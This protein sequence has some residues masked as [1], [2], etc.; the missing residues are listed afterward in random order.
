MA[1]IVTRVTGTTAVNRPLTN[2]EIDANFINL[3]AAIV[4]G[5]GG[6]LNLDGGIPSSN[7]GGIT[8]IN[9]GTP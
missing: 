5:G 9:G 8:A 1:T 7:Y 2:E 3:N 4:S 6:S